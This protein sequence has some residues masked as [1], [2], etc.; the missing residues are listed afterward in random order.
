MTKQERNMLII[1][2][3]GFFIGTAE[4]LIYYN[5][6]ESRANKNKKFVYKIP[7][8]KELLQ[9]VSIVMVTSVLTAAFTR[10]VEQALDPV[11]TNNQIEGF[12][13]NMLP[14]FDLF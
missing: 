2:T 8:T 5:L 6:G 10:G 1:T 7:P 11:E 4:A 12:K 9:T 13:R 3:A 14:A